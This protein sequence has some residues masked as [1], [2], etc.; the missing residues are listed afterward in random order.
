MQNTHPLKHTHITQRIIGCAFKVH[1]YFGKGFPEL[2]YH[3]A[4]AIE[5]GNDGVKYESEVE[6]IVMYYN[7]PVGKRRIDLLVEDK[8]L[9]ELKAVSEIENDAV[10]QILNCLNIF[11]LEVGLLLNFGSSRLEVR[12]FVYNEKLDHGYKG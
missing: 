7:E 5:L 12:R 10:S 2:I 4:L 3:R 1:N 9:V 8:I 6:R 11:N